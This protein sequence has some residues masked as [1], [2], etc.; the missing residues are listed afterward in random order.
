[1]SNLLCVVD[2]FL[3]LNLIGDGTV[4]HVKGRDGTI[5]LDGYVDHGDEIGSVSWVACP[6][7]IFVDAVC[8]HLFLAVG[9]FLTQFLYCIGS[10]DV[11]LR[12]EVCC[13]GNDIFHCCSLR[14]LNYL[15]FISL[16]SNFGSFCSFGCFLCSLLGFR[17]TATALGSLLYNGCFLCLCFSGLFCMWQRKVVEQRWCLTDFLTVG[18]CVKVL[19]VRA[20]DGIYFVRIFLGDACPFPLRRLAT[21]RSSALSCLV[22]NGINDVRQFTVRR[23]FDAQFVGYTHQLGYLHGF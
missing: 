17:L 9:H 4:K 2:R 19:T 10:V 7:T 14:Y 20:F 21:L 18:L 15:C 11:T 3:T 5:V 8:V 22:D 16:F 13:L 23:D 6:D 12:N 1:M